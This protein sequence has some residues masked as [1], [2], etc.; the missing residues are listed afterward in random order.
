MMLVGDC[1]SGPGLLRFLSAC[2]LIG[3]LLFLFFFFRDD[4]RLLALDRSIESVPFLFS[5]PVPA[6][7][8]MLSI[9]ICCV[10]LQL[11]RRGSNLAELYSQLLMRTFRT[12]HKDKN[13]KR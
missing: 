6:V 2:G 1:Q 9:I 4:L 5:L 10:L 13:Q 11:T 8:R 12:T 3:L 7:P